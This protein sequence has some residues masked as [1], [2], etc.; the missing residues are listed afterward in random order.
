[1]VRRG[2]GGAGGGR[3][4]EGEE[5]E[6]ACGV[7]KKYVT[8]RCRW[9]E[10]GRGW[11]EE[12]I[13]RLRNLIKNFALLVHVELPILPN[14][15]AIY[16]GYFFYFWFLVVASNNICER[17]PESAW[18]CE[19]QQSKQFLSKNLCHASAGP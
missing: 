18:E 12:I 7:R 17:E 8:G 3:G 10:S 2:G 15:A 4:I 5:R 6:E 14:P 16:H 1:M 13:V 19:C 11:K 9:S